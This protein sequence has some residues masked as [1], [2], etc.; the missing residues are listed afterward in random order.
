MSSTSSSAGRPDQRRV[1][2]RPPGHDR[3]RPLRQRGERVVETVGTQ[4]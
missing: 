3:A 2:V 4:V 1:H